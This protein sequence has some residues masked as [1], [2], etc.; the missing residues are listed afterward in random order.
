ML[1]TL[2]DSFITHNALF[3]MHLIPF[4]CSSPSTTSGAVYQ[5]WDSS[6]TPDLREHKWATATDVG[7]GSD[8]N[9]E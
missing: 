5:F 2:H 1:P 8:S 6:R 7:L 9:D 4:H 3:M